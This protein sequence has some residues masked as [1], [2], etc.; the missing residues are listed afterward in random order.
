MQGARPLCIPLRGSSSS[1]RESPSRENIR[2][3]EGGEGNSG[4]VLT[5][6]K[7]LRDQS[8]Q[9]MRKI[10][11]EDVNTE[12]KMAVPKRVQVSSQGFERTTTTN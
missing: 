1:L 12:K 3:G 2:E 7:E 11:Q 8:T 6:L 4:E 9:I 5:I 10:T